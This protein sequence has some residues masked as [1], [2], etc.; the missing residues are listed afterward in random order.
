MIYRNAAYAIYA[1]AMTNALVAMPAHAAN[2]VKA[3]P[4]A[5]SSSHSEN[6]VAT[7]PDADIDLTGFWTQGGYKI[8]YFEQDGSRLTSRY[9]KRSA[10]NK[11]NEIDFTATI[12]G[13]L[14]YGAHRA[15]FSR[16]LQKKCAHQIWVGMGLTLE[17][18]H[19]KLTGFRGNRTVDPKN[20]EVDNSETVDIIY[21]RMVDADGNPLK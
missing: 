3:Q 9:T 8:V 18:N 20:C 12:H 16:K 19:R 13:N 4:A 11:K 21:T 7:S 5:N 14:V 6:P 2:E 10:D 15:P 1:L 17:A